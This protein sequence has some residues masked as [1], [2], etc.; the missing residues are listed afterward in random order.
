[1]AVVKHEW[2]ADVLEKAKPSTP[3][4][5]ECQAHAA[6]MIPE[7]RR[8]IAIRTGQRKS[9]TVPRMTLERWDDIF[10]ETG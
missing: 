6:K 4:M 10:G 3:K 8:N 7:A 2:M 5:L 9:F 1:M